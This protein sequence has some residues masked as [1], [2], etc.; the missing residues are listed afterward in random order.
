LVPQ[1]RKE[2]PWVHVIEHPRNVGFAGGCNLAMRDLDGIDYVALINNDAV[3]APTWLRPLVEACDADPSVGAASSKMVF[4]PSFVALEIESPTFV[5]P[6]GAVPYGVQIV[7]MAVDGVDVWD[8]AQ[9]AVGCHTVATR[10]I[11]DSSCWTAARAEVRVPVAPDGPTPSAVAITLRAEAAKEVSIRCG[12]EV[13]TVPV[14][15]VPV[16][17]DIPLA[18]ERF[19]VINNVGSVLVE[20]GFGGDRGFLE[21]DRGQYDEPAEVFA[22]CG[23]A[24]LL[25]A[26]YLRDVGIF[27]DR[28][29]VYY[30][31]TDLAWRGRLA[32]WT[33]RYVPESTLR[34]EHAATSGEGSATFAHFVERNRL[35][36]LLRNA[37][38]SVVGSALGRF[39]GASGSIF[40]REVVRPVLGR[41][42]PRPATTVGRA[43][44]FLAFVKLA[45]ATLR[46][47][48][49]QNP[50]TGVRRAV[51]RRWM[52]AR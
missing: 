20:G 12:A 27:D 10:R 11:A 40:A 1:V 45:P 50:A 36:T 33:Y 41:H 14:G 46:S 22:W 16:T 37:P 42:A 7:G 51:V 34:H 13:V 24:V 5:P 30:E 18:G 6:G 48:R 31:D 43:R 38:W 26:R 3:P 23:G 17:V 8:E 29:F 15:T 32:G 52:V 35:L 25:S 49:E 44:I 47:R 9:F 19:D 21:R 2:L 4:F 39:L 28:Y